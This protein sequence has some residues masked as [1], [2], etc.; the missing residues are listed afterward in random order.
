MGKSINI[1]HFD[2]RKRL[3]KYYFFLNYQTF[4]VKKKYFFV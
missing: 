2:P 4:L 3:Q 1:P